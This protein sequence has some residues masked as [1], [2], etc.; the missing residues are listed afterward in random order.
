MFRRILVST[1]VVLATVPGWAQGKGQLSSP[2]TAEPSPPQLV[3]ANN[4]IGRAVESHPNEICLVCKRPLG[5]EG[6]TYLVNGQR[7]PLHIMVCYDKF[8]KNPQAYLA[9]LRPHGAFLGAADEQT[10]LS[11]GWFLGGLYI[12]LGLVFAALCA[13]RAMSSGRSPATWFGVGMV[14]NAFGYL[15]LL[16]RPEK[17]GGEIGKV[18]EGL[19]KVATTLAPVPCPGCGAMNH[20]AANRCAS[21]GN[22][23]QPRVHSEVEKAGLK[24]H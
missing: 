11:P 17:A 8:E 10:G 5:T 18:P 16:T 20:P 1:L 7:V 13:Q 23:L 22:K 12:L 14:L 2:Q 4:E 9:V 3:Q 19:A 24:S 6:V 21:C 15:L